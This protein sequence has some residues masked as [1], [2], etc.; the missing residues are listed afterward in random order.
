MTV[1]TL[2]NVPKSQGDMSSG[3]FRTAL[4]FMDGKE[5]EHLGIGRV[6]N[7][8]APAINNPVRLSLENG[9]SWTPTAVS[10]L[11]KL[12]VSADSTV[13]G[14]ITVNG[15]SVPAPGSYEGDIVVTP[16]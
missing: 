7:T 13:K 10:Y 16:A 8:P 4:Y 12:S 11:D 9:A 3:D 5:D 1:Y 6:G 15:Q 2:T 14:T